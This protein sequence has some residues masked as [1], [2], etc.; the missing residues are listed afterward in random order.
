[1]KMTVPERLAADRFVTDEDQCHITIDQ[2]LAKQTGTGKRI[3]A[4]CPARV[5]IEE[6]DGTITVEYAACLECG[7]CLAVADPG[8]LEWHYP[9]GGYGVAFREG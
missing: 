9:R 7:T 8:V 6:Q 2:R 1:M 3:V 5:Y 4:I